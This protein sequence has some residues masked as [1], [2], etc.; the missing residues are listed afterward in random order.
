MAPHERLSGG[1]LEDLTTQ[2]PDTLLFNGQADC[3]LFSF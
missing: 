2:K 1:Y 3:C